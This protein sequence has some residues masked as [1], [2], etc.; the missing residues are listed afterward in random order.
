M[1]LHVPVT[2]SNPAEW[3]RRAAGAINQLATR[4]LTVKDTITATYALEDGFDVIPADTTSA[5][6]TITL[7]KA[8]KHK[9]RVIYIKR[10]DASA[11]NLTVDGD[12]SETIDGAASITLT[13]QWEIRRL[14]S[15]G[16]GWLEL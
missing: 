10:I 11:N 5:A 3:T 4:R 2:A 16:T 9:G 1:I 15:D 7:P 8:G 6:F 12:G 13:T 14:T